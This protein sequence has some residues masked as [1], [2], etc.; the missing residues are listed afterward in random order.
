MTRHATRP[1]AKEVQQKGCLGRLPFRVDPIPLESARG[2][3]CRVAHTYRYPGVGSLGELAGLRQLLGLEREDHAA[4]IAY[5][6]RLETAE[7]RRLCYKSTNDA[8]QYGPTSF[9]GQAIGGDRVNYGHPRVC[10]GCLRERPVWWGIWDLGLVCVCPIHRCLL[11]N[12]CPSCRRKLRWQRSSV[13]ECSCRFDLRKIET[14]AA[15][16][17]LVAINAA[18]YHAAGFPQGASETDLNGA[19]YAPA[20]LALRLDSLLRIISFAGS[21]PERPSV[22]LHQSRFASHFDAAIQT[23][24]AAEGLLRDWPRSFHKMLRCMGPAKVENS[25]MLSLNDAYG[26]LYN[27]LR[28]FPREEFGFLHNAFE[29][30]VTQD[31]KGLVRGQL[32]HHSYSQWIGAAEAGRLIGTR[33]AAALVRNG[34]LKG[35]FV[36]LRRGPH[37]ECWI[38][39]ESLNQWMAERTAQVSC[40]M[41][42]REAAQAL[43]L[44]RTTVLRVAKAGLIRDAK[45]PEH[46]R[47]RGIYLRREDVMKIKGA[48][49]K[50]AV[51]DRR[52]ALKSEE[53]MALRRAIWY[54]GPDSGL[55]AAIRAVVDGTLVPIAHTEQFPG[56]TGYFF[57]LAQLRKYRPAVQARIRT[58]EFLCFTEAAS[59]LGTTHEVIGKLAA[60]GRLGIP[61]ECPHGLSK[62]LLAADVERFRRRY[63]PVIVL[64]KR[65][66]TSSKWLAEYLESRYSSHVLAVRLRTSRTMFVP[67]QIASRVRIPGKP[68][69]A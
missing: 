57:P 16:T 24:C 46:H 49:E 22:F 39:R 52:D 17:D 55:P 27:Q 12:R 48:F 18:I 10:P 35:I 59:M 37:S 50:H 29:D 8:G 47:P 21:L 54:L 67:R 40:L 65:F 63:V 31:W 53:L 14:K 32:R 68:T 44:T 38:E 60:C 3:L 1:S 45:G 56:I 19:G 11:E 61:T 20:L 62:L 41:P 30:F 13:H 23:S 7:W 25:A 66:G 28:T 33:R 43:G 26:K 6:L 5:A 58:G 34:E 15:G 2:Y 4:Q 36:K 9:F 51:P 42:R 64:A 69:L